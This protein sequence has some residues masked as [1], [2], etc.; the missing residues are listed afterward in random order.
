MNSIFLML[1][2][3]EVMKM[4]TNS[5]F[6]IVSAWFILIV[7]GLTPLA[8]AET[9]HAASVPKATQGNHLQPARAIAKETVKVV[10]KWDAELEVAP[11]SIQE[12]TQF[13]LG[14]TNAAR[15]K[16]EN[17][18]TLSGEERNRLLELIGRTETA[19]LESTESMRKLNVMTAAI[20]FCYGVEW[21]W[22]RL[23][24]V[25]KAPGIINLIKNNASPGGV[26]MGC[27]TLAWTRNAGDG[28]PNFLPTLGAGI[29]VGPKVELAEYEN[30]QRKYA[31]LEPV[32]GGAVMVPLGNGSG[33]LKIGDLIGAYVGGGGDVAL[34]GRNLASGLVSSTNVT[35]LVKSDID[36]WPPR[37]QPKVAMIVGTKSETGQNRLLTPRLQ[38]LYFLGADIPYREE[39]AKR[40]KAVVQAIPFFGKVD[41]K[42][43]NPPEKTVVPDAELTRLLKEGQ[44]STS[45]S[46]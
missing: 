16:V 33:M 5:N 17:D 9:E 20:N 27:I 38:T 23:L 4:F 30:G 25:N 31:R 29:L 7:A 36:V 28:S 34:E 40:A 2:R 44:A 19:F 39:I 46:N 15:K 14:R 43:A 45:I 13:F 37:I 24:G 18:A 3:T 35:A 12:S 6:T 32:K 26:G 11:K 1:N 10:D 41:A 42:M 21:D 22:S 8:R